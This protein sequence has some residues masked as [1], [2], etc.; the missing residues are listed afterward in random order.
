MK[1][2]IL[3]MLVIGVMMLGTATAFANI[4]QA[5][6]TVV[7]GAVEFPTGLVKLV[8]GLVWTIGEAIALPFRLIF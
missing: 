2:H 7:E 8:G 4:D 6:G 1:K 3:M 5:V